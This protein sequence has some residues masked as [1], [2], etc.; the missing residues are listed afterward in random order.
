[1]A[2]ISR[3]L[4]VSVLGLIAA[5][6]A[7]FSIGTTQARGDTGD[8]NPTVSGSYLFGIDNNS[9]IYEINPIS[10]EARLINDDVNLGAKSNSLAYDAVNAR[11]YF[12]NEKGSQKTVQVWD[13]KNAPEG[14]SKTWATWDE[15]GV[16]SNGIA[17]ATWTPGT[18][19]EAGSYT[20]ATKGGS[21]EL[22]K[23]TEDAVTQAISYSCSP[24]N[25]AVNLGGYGDIALDKTGVIYGATT[26]RKFYSLPTTGVGAFSPSVLGL[27]VTDEGTKRTCQLAFDL[28]ESSLFCQGQGNDVSAGSSQK[29]GAWYTVD[30]SDGKLDPILTHEG[31]PFITAF[32]GSCEDNQKCGMRDIAGVAYTPFGSQCVIDMPSGTAVQQGTTSEAVAD[33]PTVKVTVGGDAVPGIEVT[34]NVVS[35]GAGVVNGGSLEGQS[36]VTTVTDQE[37]V[38]TSGEWVL[39]SIPGTNRVEATTPDLTC[40]LTFDAVGSD[41]APPAPV[42]PDPEP[43]PPSSPTG[44]DV[45][46]GTKPVSPNQPS[47]GNQ[48][49]TIPGVEVDQ[50]LETEKLKPVQ[51][52]VSQCRWSTK[53]S[54]LAKW[55]SPKDDASVIGYESRVRP[56]GGEWTRW[57]ES[58]ETSTKRKGW[59]SVRKAVQQKQMKRSK[60]QIVKVQV[61]PV[62]ETN[63][64]P[65]RSTKARTKPCRI[66]TVKGFG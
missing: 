26:N 19:G 10:Q 22:C 13:M 40:E 51:K 36:T 2:S 27:T 3:V 52:L 54:I 64:G 29:A 15:A 23:A 6:L 14:G 31:L 44:P 43:A 11:L 30:R 46:L 1:M 39:S 61:R 28:T 5:L 48:N 41:S 58:R 9:D 7:T 16:P 24:F 66:K 57:K 65:K 21:P 50:E 38:A 62:S 60:S 18:N 56:K 8:T 47:P 12:T 37:G 63:V 25:P 17:N 45:P 20:F 53:S 33:A 59:F 32:A 55:R 49:V 34:F 42:R 35:D 4:L